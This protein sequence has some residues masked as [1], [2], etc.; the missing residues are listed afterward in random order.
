MSSTYCPLPFT[1]L[2]T[3]P[4]GGCTLCCISDHK[5]GASRSKNYKENGGTEWLDLNNHSV[6][7]IYN[8]DYF[9]EVRLQMLNNEEPAACT[10]CYDEE[11]KGITSKRQS[12]AEVF[13]HFDSIRA[14]ELTGEDGHIDLDIRFV[15]L[16]LGNLCNVRCRTC[17]PAS[18]SQW[19]NDYKKI[20][21]SLDFVTKYGNIDK[22]EYKWPEQDN[23]WEDLF[24]SAP[25]LELVYINGGEP[26]LIKKHWEYLE[27]LIAADRAKNMTLWYNIN[28]TNLPDKTFDIWKQFGKIMVSASIDDLDERNHYIRHP[29]KWEDVT[30]HLQQIMA[31][32]WIETS[33]CQTVS[34]YNYAYLGEFHK[35][36]T[37]DLG[38]HVHLN[39]VYDP[40]FLS[41]KIIHPVARTQIHSQ[42]RKDFGNHHALG[43]LLSMFDN[44]E[45]DEDSWKKFKVY[46]DRLDLIRNQDWREV[47]PK[48]VELCNE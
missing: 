26:T 19:R 38:L 35:W 42:F 11:R 45:W 46:N 48:L 43:N 14:R 9:K 24:D 47:F 4:H 8:S 39:Y 44:E 2:A 10:R 6:D 5:N 3:H 40:K 34:A 32:D 31:E 20:E 29:S 30:N 37:K 22:D 15:E 7:D 33:I 12:E 28:M 21:A 18:S 27:K 13:K 17:N 36:A 16:R 23:F 1:H 25:N 41:P